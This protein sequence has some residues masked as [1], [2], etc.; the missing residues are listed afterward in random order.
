M[1]LSRDV[2]NVQKKA[3]VVASQVRE[4]ADVQVRSQDTQDSLDWTMWL[5]GFSVTTMK[6]FFGEHAGYFAMVL[7]Q[8]ILMKDPE[9]ATKGYDQDMLQIMSS[10][11]G[12]EAGNYPHDEAV[13]VADF[14]QWFAGLP[15]VV[16][17]GMVLPLPAEQ[18]KVFLKAVA[19]GTTLDDGT[20][21]SVVASI[22]QRQGQA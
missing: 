3:A 9:D 5:F 12:A 11:F 16:E 14:Q 13:M 21:D 4:L 10:C 6:L 15:V 18:T 1:E 17:H 19:D 7:L 2:R 22:R 20:L 8:P